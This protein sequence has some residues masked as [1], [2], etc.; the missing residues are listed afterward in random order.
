ME[1]THTAASN[2]KPEE[3]LSVLFLRTPLMVRLCDEIDKGDCG[4]N[5]KSRVARF[6]TAMFP[7][8]PMARPI[9]TAKLCEILCQGG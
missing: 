1:L 7:V 3:C 8:A 9:E 4:A 6:Q 5:S 2:S